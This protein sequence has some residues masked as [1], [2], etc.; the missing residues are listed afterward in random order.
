MVSF[1]SLQLH[2]STVALL[3]R[4]AITT[5]TPIQRDLIPLVIA[6]KDVVAQS[7]TGS[8]KTLGFA[9]PLIEKIERRDGIAALILAP[10]RELALQIAQE[11]IKFSQGK[12]LG[13]TAVYGGVSMND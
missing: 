2:K 7:E 5:P 4:H 13:I 10:T 9:L 6:G 1:E 11:F 8:G 12:H 3:A